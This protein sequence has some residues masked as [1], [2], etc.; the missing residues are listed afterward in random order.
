MIPDYV[1]D[2]KSMKIMKTNFVVSFNYTI[3]KINNYLMVNFKSVKI[4][5]NPSPKLF[6]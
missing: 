3:I 5:N 6:I 4:I 2:P 1:F